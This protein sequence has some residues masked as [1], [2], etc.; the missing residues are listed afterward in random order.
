MKPRLLVDAMLGSLARW[1]RILGYDARYA[2]NVASDDEIARVA[3]EE[4]RIVVTRDRRLSQRT[5][6]ILVA[7]DDD[8]D[9]QIV[10]VLVATGDRPSEKDLFTRCSLC[11]A[12]LDRAVAGEVAGLVPDGVLTED[13]DFKKCP[14]CGQVYW[15]GTHWD[16]IIERFERLKRRLA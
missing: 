1:L 9:E 16:R 12:P 4:E 6:S 15:K 3:E 11:N 5:K 14:T 2:D 10:K 13:R 8:L 7:M